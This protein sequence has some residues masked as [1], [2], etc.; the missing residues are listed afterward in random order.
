MVDV[1]KTMLLNV[2]PWFVIEDLRNSL[3][4]RIVLL[5]WSQR[6]EVLQVVLVLHGLI[7]GATGL[8]RVRSGGQGC[9]FGNVHH[10][11]TS[12]TR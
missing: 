10:Q 7:T 9:P 3:V 11:A 2:T 1:F 4:T 6:W 12:E 5:S 8:A